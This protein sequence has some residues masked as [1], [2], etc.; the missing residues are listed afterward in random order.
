MRAERSG[1]KQQIFGSFFEQGHVFDLIVVVFEER[2]HKFHQPR[3]RC[4]KG[5]ILI[6]LVIC[7][8]A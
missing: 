3:D 7:L 8:I 4:V 5:E 1:E 6:S 2:V